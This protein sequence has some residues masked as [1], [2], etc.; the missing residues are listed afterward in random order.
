[1]RTG[2]SETGNGM[3]FYF[4]NANCCVETQNKEREGLPGKRTFVSQK[5]DIVEIR[6]P[7]R[8]HG[9]S[10][11]LLM[12]RGIV[13]YKFYNI[14][15][16]SC[17]MSDQQQLVRTTVPSQINKKNILSRSQLKVGMMGVTI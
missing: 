8:Q 12:A 11:M 10:A 13:I 3:F 4:F 16:Y 7:G 5:E 1:M 15:E 6:R 2:I 14:C 9:Q 17:R